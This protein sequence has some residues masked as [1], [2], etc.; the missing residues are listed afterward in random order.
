MLE[1][2][3][4][5]ADPLQPL[6]MKGMA[7][8]LYPVEERSS[9]YSGPHQ[10]ASYRYSRES[11]VE[12]IGTQRQPGHEDDRISH[13]LDVEHGFRFLRA[14]RLSYSVGSTA[15]HVGRSVAC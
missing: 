13:L 9:Q 2:I 14:V 5:P 8:D 6:A 11:H 7:L 12:C 1:V 3:H 4:Y 15:S 10:Q